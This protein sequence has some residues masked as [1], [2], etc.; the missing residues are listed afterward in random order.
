MPWLGNAIQKEED[1]TL[2]ELGVTVETLSPDMAEKVQ[3]AFVE[4]I[5]AL[6]ADCCGD[7]AAELRTI[8]R[9]A[10]LTE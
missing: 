6:G 10:G 9:D 7:A 4:S 1:E 2:D 5:W 8:A 3:S